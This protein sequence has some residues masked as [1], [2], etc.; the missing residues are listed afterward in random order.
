MDDDFLL[1]HEDCKDGFCDHCD[2]PIWRC[3][4]LPVC[5]GGEK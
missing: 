2:F 3:L 4:C 5:H 1:V